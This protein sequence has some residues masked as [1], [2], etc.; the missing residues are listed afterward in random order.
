MSALPRIQFE[1]TLGLVNCHKTKLFV[2]KI[3]YLIII[4]CSYADLAKRHAVLLFVIIK[5][6]ILYGWMKTLPAVLLRLHSLASCDT[7]ISKLTATYLAIEKAP[8]Q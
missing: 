3:K 7:K 1:D 8:S 2:V 5:E 6:T 4:I